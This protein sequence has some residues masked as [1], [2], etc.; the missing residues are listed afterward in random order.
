LVRAVDLGGEGPFAD[1]RDVRLR[2]PDHGSDPRRA[3][4]DARGSAA[5]NRAGGGH[6]GIRAVIQ[7]EERPV[8]SFEQDPLALTECSVDEQG[9]VGDV[10]AQALRA[11]LAAL[12][13]LFELDRLRAVDAFQ[14]EVLLGERDLDLLPEDLRVEQVLDAD[15]DSK[16]LVCVRGA[17]P[18]TSRPDPKPAETAL[19]RLV[20]RAVPRHDHVRV[21]REPDAVDGQPARL[22]VVELGDE[23]LGIDHAAGADHALLLR[24]DAR[25]QMAK[26]EGLSVD[27]DRVSCVGPAVVAADQIRVLGE[28]VDDLA[29]ALVSPLGTD[30]D[31]R[32]HART[33]VAWP[34]TDAV[35]SRGKCDA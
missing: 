2:D 7:V 16:G 17:D 9:R 11:R 1:P 32:G 21:P 3:D 29:L 26:L 14:P 4:P 34:E 8:C 24:D 18:A 25:G 27:L 23:L 13:E 19:A 22:Q 6:E 20:D 15:A 30:D 31:G 12:G 5:G 33:L 28:Q 35:G 10:R